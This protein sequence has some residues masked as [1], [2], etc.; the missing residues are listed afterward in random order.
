M[1]DELREC[2]Q[3]MYQ[4]DLEAVRSFLGRHA[5][6]AEYKHELLCMAAEKGLAGMMEEIIQMGASA[7]R[8]G[9]LQGAINSGSVDAVACALRHG[10]TV[11]KY[12]NGVLQC[13]VLERAIRKGTLEIVKMIVDQGAYLNEGLIHYSWSVA[14]SS[15]H[16]DEE[17]QRRKEIFHYIGTVVASP[18]VP[19]RFPTP[20]FD[21]SL[22]GATVA[23]RLPGEFNYLSRV[24]DDLSDLSAKRDYAAW[25][26]SRDTQRS[27]FLHRWLAAIETDDYSNL[28]K[29]ESLDSDWLCMIGFQ[30]E[31]WI[32]EHELDDHRH[33]LLRLVRPAIVFN[34]TIVQ[35]QQIPIGMS[36]LGGFPDLA[37]NVAWPRAKNCTD[38]YD[39]PGLENDQPCGFWGQI[40]LAELQGTMAARLL[41]Q[42]G[43]LSFFFYMNEAG[44]DGIR[45]LYQPNAVNLLR[46]QP[47]EPLLPCNETLKTQG[48]RFVET[49]TLPHTR[50]PWANDLSAVAEIDSSERYYGDQNFM[51]YGWAT[52]GDDPT[53]DRD[54]HHLV[55]MDPNV[56]FHLQ[57]RED[58]LKACNFDAV[59][60]VWIDYD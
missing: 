14:N 13:P 51:G 48:L 32:R 9:V 53:P 59:K 44:R 55:L 12:E 19:I 3:L 18:P 30:L 52:T 58:D 42:E 20:D 57:I 27:D 37:P 50:G 10:A 22:F 36:K 34:Q 7:Q 56:R 60:V 29:P 47:P 21:L 17:K 49:L 15:K 38:S 16:S 23:A 1:A 4:G 26:S 54:W 40:N 31:S 33:T 35:D 11:N 2:V 24:V 45:V 28:T 8:F 5:D 25:L 43:M 46:I 6:N 41:P 39:L